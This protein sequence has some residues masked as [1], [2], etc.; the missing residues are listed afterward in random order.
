MNTP[1]SSSGGYS[2]STY[3]GS[4]NTQPSRERYDLPP[5]NEHEDGPYP[6]DQPHGKYDDAG[7]GEHEGPPPETKE[8]TGEEDHGDIYGAEN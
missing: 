3:Y 5:V 2:P 4:H 1:S 8:R 6:D 7:D